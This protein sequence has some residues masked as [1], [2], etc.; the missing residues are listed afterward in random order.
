MPGD[1]RITQTSAYLRMLLSRPGQP[2]LAWT[3]HATDPRPGE[4]DYRAAARVLAQHAAA[5]ATAGDLADP[6]DT[7][8]RALDGV[9]LDEPI[10]DALIA[11]FAIGSRHAARLR[12]LLRG[13]DAVLVITDAALPAA[14]LPREIGPDRHDLVCAHDLHTLGPDGSP[15]EHQTIQVIRSTVDGLDRMPYRFDTDELVVDV[16]RGGKLDE[17][18]YRVADQLYGVDILFD[19]PLARGE[20]TLMHLR[21]T[22][23][24]KTPP[25]PE[26][27]RGVLNGPNDLTMWVNFHPERVPARV[28]SARWDRLDHESIVHEE[29]I[30]LD[31]EYSVHARFGGI[32]QA[33]VGFHWEWE[34]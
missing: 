27:R 26:F 4:I 24:Y 3:R 25:P 34:G 28:W 33:I 15:A 16:V 13:S 17:R 19:Q 6:L 1:D 5:P 10:L 12:N 18:L 31:G 32:A 29:L 20:T 21:T 14:R 9:A 23:R 8:R 22:F 11:A 7:I 30:E 2:R